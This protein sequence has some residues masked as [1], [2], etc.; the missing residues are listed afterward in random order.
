MPYQTVRFRDIESGTLFKL[1]FRGNVW[2]KIPKKYEVGG[3]MAEYTVNAKAASDSTIRVA[4]SD[5]QSILILP[6]D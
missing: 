4:F 3:A 2:I 1:S 6:E 5:N